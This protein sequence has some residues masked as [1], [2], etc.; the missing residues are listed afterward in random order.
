MMPEMDR[1]EAVRAVAA[2]PCQSLLTSVIAHIRVEQAGSVASGIG[3]IEL[4]EQYV[5]CSDLIVVPL[6]WADVPPPPVA[7]RRFDR[8]YRRLRR[9]D[10]FPEVFRAA[11]SARSISTLILSTVLSVFCAR[12]SVARS[13]RR[14]SASRSEPAES[15]SL[16]IAHHLLVRTGQ[17]FVKP[18]H[19]DDLSPSADLLFR[20]VAK[21]FGKHAYGIVLTGMSVMVHT[22]ATAGL[23]RSRCVDHRCKG[24]RTVRW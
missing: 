7:V 9:F 10:R 6:I 22:V 5:W 11:V 20:S 14:R 21:S 17:V 23:R 15:M 12:K 19:P 1:I 16:A 3:Q 4:V 24:S 13:S 18:A 8:G 2:G